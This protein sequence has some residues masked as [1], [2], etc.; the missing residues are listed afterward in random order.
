[1]AYK[2]AFV[3][4]ARAGFKDLPASLVHSLNEY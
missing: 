2:A 3:S 1:M 4:V